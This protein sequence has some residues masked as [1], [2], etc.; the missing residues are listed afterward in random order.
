MTNQYMELLEGIDSTNDQG[1]FERFGSLRDTIFATDESSPE[2]RETLAFVIDWTIKPGRSWTEREEGLSA[3]L[4][5]F[6]CDLLGGVDLAPLDTVYSSL[7]EELQGYVDELFERPD[8]EQR[9]QKR[10]T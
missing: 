7:S 4:V 3:L 1:R 2:L 5:A 10:E 8:P 6:E 9:R